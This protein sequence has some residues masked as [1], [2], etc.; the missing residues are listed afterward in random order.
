MLRTYR[1]GALGAMMDEYERAAGELTNLVKTVDESRFV[2]DYPQEADKCRSIQ[3]IMRHVI[4]AA[5]GFANEIRA[6]L[7]ISVT[8]ALPTKLEDKN[9]SIVAFESALN[10]TAAAFEDKWAMSEDEIERVTMPTP[11][12]T[13]YTLEQML[14]HAIVHILRHRRQIERLI[15][16]PI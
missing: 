3:K 11:W 5:Y 2:V 16:N 7:N 15:D 8:A 1:T 4:R 14:E 12:G 10:Y 6:A 9:G 13:T